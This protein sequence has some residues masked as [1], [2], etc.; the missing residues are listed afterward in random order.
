MCLCFLSMYYNNIAKAENPF[1]EKNQ[2]KQYKNN[3]NHY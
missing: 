3:E 2:E 1:F